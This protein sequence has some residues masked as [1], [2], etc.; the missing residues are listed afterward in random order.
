M[1]NLNKIIKTNL[2]QL[3]NSNK[4]FE[5]IFEIIHSIED[6][7][8]SELSDGYKVKK[9]TYKDIKNQSILMGRFFNNELKDIQKNDYVGII[10]DNSPSWVSSFWGLLMAGYKPMLL[11]IRL[12]SKLNQEIIELLKIKCVI[13]DKDYNLN[14]NMI[15][16]NNI[17]LS[18]LNTEVEFNWAN[19]IALST[20]ATTLNIKICVY[21]GQDIASQITNTDYIVKTNSMIKERYNG[22]IK[23][24]AFL[25]FYHIFGLIATYFWFSFFGRT[26]VFLKDFSSET[27]IKTARKHKVTHIFAVPMVWNTIAKEIK[28]E[29][30][31]KDEKTQKRFEKGLKISNKLQKN[32]S[33]LGFKLTNKIMTEVQEKI[34]GSSIKF[35]I[36]GGGYISNSTIELLNGIGYPLYNGYGM[37]EIGITSVELRKGIRERIS[38]SIGKPLP[39]VEYKIENEILY[40]KGKSI[41]SKI[42]SKQGETIIDHNEWFKT[43]DLAT[44]DKKGNYYIIGR[45]DDVV[46]AQNGE[47][48]NPDLIEKEI[49]LVNA[50]RFCVLGLETEGKVD[51]SLVVEVPGEITIL[52]TQKIL[53]EID[54]VI[55]KTEKNNCK[56]E[57]IFVTNDKI[58][59]DTAIKVS[60]SILIK[61]IN[62]N[63]VT[64]KSLNEFK[65]EN[66]FDENKINNEVYDEVLEMFSQ[67]LHKEKDNISGNDHFIFDLGG[68]SLEYI[69]L[70]INLKSKYEIDFNFGEGESCYTVYEIVNYILKKRD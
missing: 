64:L 8:F 68:A 43:N 53:E 18:N 24:M 48:I 37:S 56:I 62:T 69:T 21:T 41:C 63:E 59:A 13:A 22:E 4:T 19:E 5:D 47:K 51:L 70:L 66:V 9:L 44:C 45:N 50:R 28:K 57:K 20:S 54:E 16:T 27:I 39:T 65:E 2:V 61:K 29:I 3:N 67:V 52:K 35:L 7:V 10:M 60:R 30:S 12:G 31:M 38:G 17:D 40:V 33:K 25:P 32:G 11:N 36:T 14:C 34:F 42:I 55:K 15:Y 23:I 46:V 49:T 58:A 1:E 26:L 6:N